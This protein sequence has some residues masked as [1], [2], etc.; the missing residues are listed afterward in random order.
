[1]YMNSRICKCDTYPLVCGLWHGIW[2]ILSRVLRLSHS[3]AVCCR[4]LHCVAL[5]CSVMHHIA[6]QYLQILSRVLRL[7][8]NRRIATTAAVL[9]RRISHVTHIQSLPKKSHYTWD[10]RIR[11]T[12]AY[13]SHHAVAQ[14]KE[15][16]CMPGVQTM[17]AV[18]LRVPWNEGGER[19]KEIGSCFRNHSGPRPA[20]ANRNGGGIYQNAPFCSFCA[21]LVPRFYVIKLGVCQPRKKAAVR[22]SLLGPTR[23]IGSPP[24]A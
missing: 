11:I 8:R 15:S 7:S 2:L 24:P 18:Y 3:V 13:W 1:M 19:K 10:V 9:T 21:V 4:V 12:S 23:W 20:I 16:E 22:D 17:I 14:G 6:V 5:C